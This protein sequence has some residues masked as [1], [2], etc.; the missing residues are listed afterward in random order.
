MTPQTADQTATPKATDPKGTNDKFEAAL[1]QI[2]TNFAS[3]AAFSG[4]LEAFIRK[5]RSIS[6][7]RKR[8]KIFKRR[9]F[10]TPMALGAV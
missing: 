7:H 10:I 1:N 8:R 4:A 9:K 5:K 3:P 6:L 2:Y